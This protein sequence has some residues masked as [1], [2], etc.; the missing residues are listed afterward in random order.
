MEPKKIYC[1]SSKKVSLNN[2]DE[3]RIN[4][5]YKIIDYKKNIAQLFTYEQNSIDY[6]ILFLS[7]HSIKRLDVKRINYLSHVF[8]HIVVVGNYKVQSLINYTYLPAD[9]FGSDIYKIIRTIENCK[10]NIIYSLNKYADCCSNILQQLGFNKKFKG[11]AYLI[12]ASYLVPTINLK[13]KLYNSL[14]QY[15]ADKFK[16]TIVSVEKCIRQSIN[17]ASKNDKEV[18]DLL[19]KLKA[20]L[21]NLTNKKFIIELN[22]LIMQKYL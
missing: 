8:K 2:I 12:E 6:L 9:R 1:Y 19:T 21:P 3:E 5:C 7:S 16:T 17:C 15:V 14:Y 22:R 11:F 4:R 10:H 18:V 13:G 20:E